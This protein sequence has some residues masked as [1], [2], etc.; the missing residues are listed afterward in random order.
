MSPRP[1]QL[2]DRYARAIALA[3]AGR[4]EAARE[5]LTALLTHAPDA[6]ELH[7]QLSQLAH[8]AGD[9][10][11]RAAHLDRALAARP[12][13]AQLI[14]AGIA[15]FAAIGAEDRALKLHDRRIAAS[16]PRLHAETD[17]AIFLQQIGRF[18]EAEALLRRLIER[19]P[20]EGVLYRT[21]FATL[22]VGPDEPLLDRLRKL[23]NHRDPGA[24]SR[25]NGHFAMAKALEDLGAYGE[26][27]DHLHRANRL[28]RKL[29]PY[30]R[31]AR[32][33]ED[34]AIR[35]A[36]DGA[37]LT[38]IAA[39]AAPWPVFVTGLPRSGTTL[40]ERVIARHP[41]IRAG[42][43]LAHALRLVWQG[44][45]H[46]GQM[47]PLARVPEA[48][49]AELAAAYRTGLRRDTGATRGAVTDKSIQSHL[50]YG[51][52]AR[53]LPQA[54]FV[55]IHRD[56]R[57]VAVSIYKNHFRTGTHRYGN[58]L[59]DIAHAIRAYRDSIA[60][61]R[62]RLGDRLTE[63]RYEDLVQRPEDG[64]RAL[65]AAAGQDWTPE[66]A[67]PAAAGNGPVRTLSVAQARRPIH[68]GSVGGWRRYEAELGPFFEAWEDDIWD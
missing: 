44:F 12:G 58:D 10:A 39:D 21:L 24:E 19:H 2:Q 60:F 32:L 55:A 8:D 34:R 56:P 13:D 59:A 33:A 43:E 15:A 47:T 16:K 6:P 17:K 50:V 57:D 65:I 27:F 42:G 38:P 51:F 54:R 30:D 31:A 45:V 67:D 66:C 49:L 18:A 11:A 25:L 63:Y 48:R 36:Q 28:Q 62:D 46:E 22:K 68:A 35:L 1:A 53:A 9:L 5:A 4:A 41:G 37:D 64:A 23:L 20:R 52:L 3:R 7:A 61:W 29:A 14:E 40:A 26:V